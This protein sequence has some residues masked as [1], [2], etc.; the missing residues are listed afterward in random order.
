LRVL[1]CGRIAQ[2]GIIKTQEINTSD[3]I[4]LSIKKEEDDEA[5]LIC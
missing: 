4:W 5:G 3:K 2:D 1:S